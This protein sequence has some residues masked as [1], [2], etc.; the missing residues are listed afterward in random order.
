M[1]VNPGTLN[2][3]IQIVKYISTGQD[4]D[5]FELQEERV[6]VRECYASVKNTSGKEIINANSQFSEVKKRFLIRWSSVDINTD[7]VIAH[8]G[9]EYDIEYINPYYDGTDY[10]EI[11]TSMRERV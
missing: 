7:M 5:G 6:I 3:K 10:V 1:Y 4:K 2:K 11:Y 8:S 9:K